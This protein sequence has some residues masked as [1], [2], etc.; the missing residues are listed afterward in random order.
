M[1]TLARRLLTV[2]GYFLATAV[3]SLT[4][5][6]WL[7]L[8]ALISLHPTRAGTLRSALF[9][10]GYLW[11][12]SVGIVASFVIW[13]RHSGGAPGSPRREAFLR[14]N[15]RL[16]CTW[17]AALAGLAR[18]LFALRFQVTGLDALAGPS[19]VLVPRHASI[20]DTV[21]PI[22]FYARPL[23]RPLRYVLKRE[24]LM[25]PCLDIVGNRLPNYFVDRGAGD[26]AAEVT[27]I[28][29]LLDGLGDDGVLIYPEGTRFSVQKRARILARGGAPAAA[30]ARWPHLLPPRYRG[31]LAL[32]EHNPGLDLLFCAHS[33]FEGSSH[34]AS[35]IN[36]SWVG[37]DVRVHFWRVPFRDIPSDAAAQR[38]F[39]DTQWDCMDARVS[40]LSAR[41]GTRA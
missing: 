26:S 14:A 25:D 41:N 30:A 37:A 27:G 24:L 28:V 36:G 38:T 11:C 39:F 29:G 2:P 5:P 10:T 34:F 19:V 12:E 9:V 32:L 6:L 31:I 16:Q 8:T 15:F 21:I 22:V 40:E 20:G 1:N 4:S 35:L 3:V 17:G 18:H 7:P 33:G 13:C 23:Q